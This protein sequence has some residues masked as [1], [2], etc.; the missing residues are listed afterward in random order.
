MAIWSHIGL[1][2]GYQ[3]KANGFCILDIA[4]DAPERKWRRK[5]FPMS[6]GKTEVHHPFCRNSPGWDY[7][8]A[9]EQCQWPS[10]G[11]GRKR[12]GRLETRRSGIEAYGYIYDSGHGE[13]RILYYILMLTRRQHLKRNLAASWK[14]KRL[15]KLMLATLHHH[16]AWN[17]HNGHINGVAAVGQMETAHESNIM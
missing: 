14:K 2:F 7:I 10:S 5:I 17:G 8:Q 4:R 9:P 15:F 16:P 11:P 3:L 1:V 6:G 12:I 13:R